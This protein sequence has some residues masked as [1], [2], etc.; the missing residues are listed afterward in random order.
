[1]SNTDSKKKV[2]LFA[3]LNYIFD[4]NILL[5]ALERDFNI[6]ESS[7]DFGKN[8]IPMLLSEGKNIYIYRR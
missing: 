3:K 5:N 4:K 7:H 6:K 8:V 1:M 2:S